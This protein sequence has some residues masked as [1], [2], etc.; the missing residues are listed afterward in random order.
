MF[1]ALSSPAQ[2]MISELESNADMSMDSRPDSLGKK[3]EKKF[4]PTEVRA[5]T[6]DERFGTIRET[7][8]DT[9]SRLFFNRN[10]AEGAEGHY[11]S[12][13]NVGSPRMSRI[14]MERPGMSDFLFI[15]N[16]DMFFVNPDQVRFYNTKSPFMYVDYNACGNKTS[17]DDHVKVTYTNNAGKKF[18]FGGIFD[19]IYGQGFYDKLNTSFMNASAWASYISDK[20]NLHISYQHDFM[21]MAE[22]GGIIDEGYITRP[23]EMPGNYTSNDIPTFL[24]ATWNRQ[25]FD[26]IH[27]NH[28]YNIG[29]YRTEEI[30]SVT[31]KKV[32]VPVSKVF[33][34]FKLQ[35]SYHNYRSYKETENYHT[36]TYLPGDSTQDYHRSF[37]VKNLAGIS[38]CEGFNKWALFGL[39]AYVGYEYNRYTLPDFITGTKRLQNKD[40]SE[41][42]VMVGGQI[43]RTQGNTIHYNADAEF[44]VAGENIGQFD[45]QGHGEANIPLWGDT[46]QVAVNAFVKNTNPKF[47]F[48]HFH[49]KH[50]WWDIDPDKEFKQRVEGV[51]TVPHT[52]TKLTVGVENIKNY[53]Y[54]ANNGSVIK[55]NDNN[56]VVTNNLAPMQC[57]DNIQILS[58][59]LRQDFKLGI[60]HFDNDITYQTTTNK[61]VLPLPMLSTYSNLYL[62]FKIAQVLD[63]ELGG[64]MKFFTEYYAPDYSPVNQQFMTQNKAKKTKIGNYPIISVYANFNLKRTRFY[65]QYYHVNQSDG[66]YFWA[67]GYPINPG[68]MRLGISWNFYD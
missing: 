52:K 41:H 35:K 19:Y 30:D 55:D 64:D 67:P 15:D 24:S 16:F 28:Q 21:K 58:A 38:L 7:H 36:N 23:E 1:V 29:F 8:V 9:L 33:H 42:N 32:F 10:L 54:F 34:T 57:S 12:L 31:T 13:G 17:G 2:R 20:Y 44:I 51:I 14:F 46:A 4:V 37:Q 59:N 66:R 26:L 25:E 68:G 3:K 5:W 6:I 63:T 40:F 45:V 27:L 39:N 22:S 43:I 56:D 47:F 49:S 62:K 53:C 11:N 60:L 50:A 61:D 18:N 48:R 65:V